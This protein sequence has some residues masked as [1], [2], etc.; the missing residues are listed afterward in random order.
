MPSHIMWAARD[1]SGLLRKDTSTITLGGRMQPAAQ[2]ASQRTAT[3]AARPIA[4]FEAVRPVRGVTTRG[5]AGEDDAVGGG[6]AA[7][8]RW[9]A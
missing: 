5:V 8:G 1:S 6:T 9:P 3:T 4:N 7:G 2:A